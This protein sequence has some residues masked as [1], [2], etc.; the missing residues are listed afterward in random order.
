MPALIAIIADLLEG[1][2]MKEIIA[3]FGKQFLKSLGRKFAGSISPKQ[4]AKMLKSG[5]DPTKVFKSLKSMEKGHFDNLMK[6][7]QQKGMK[8]ND[9]VEFMFNFEGQMKLSSSFLQYGLFTIDKNNKNTGKLI[10]AISGKEYDFGRVKS[11]L[12]LAMVQ[13]KGINGTGA[14]SVLWNTL[15]RHKRT[16]SLSTGGVAGSIDNL[17]K[18]NRR[19]NLQIA[20]NTKYIN[21]LKQKTQRSGKVVFTTRKR[22]RVPKG[23]KYLK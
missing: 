13:A 6:H 18:N 15:W 10:L 22:L 16:N 11:S 14:G 12:W 23:F 19:V 1:M 21:K 4:I 17:I 3:K 8:E 9:V 7:L 5:I 20:R 2:A